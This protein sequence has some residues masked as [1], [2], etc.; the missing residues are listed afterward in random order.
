MR[1]NQ[2]FP[3]LA[4]VLFPVLAATGGPSALAQAPPAAPVRYTEARE[5]EVRREVRLSG[6]VESRTV[7]LVASEVEGLV[8]EMLVREGERVKQ[9]QVLARLRT[10]PLDLRRRAAA[11]ELK[12][13]EARSKLA[14]RGLERAR[15]LFS[16]GAISQQQLDEAFYE[17][18]AWQ[19]RVEK[20]G[21]DI[22]RIE[23]D[24]ERSAIR[25]PF[26]GAVVARRA[27][28]GQWIE[29][30][31][32]VVEMLAHDDLEVV[33]EAPERYYGSLKPGAAVAVT[34]E[35]LPGLE[36]GGRV[37]GVVP[38]ADPQS[39]TFQIRVRISS[40]GGR[41]SAGM[42]AQVA[43]P[44][45][46]PYRAT[47]VPKDAVVADGKERFVYTLDGSST[48][49]VVPVKTGEGVGSWVVVEG[50]VKPGHKVVTRGN[51]RLRPSQS[52]RGEP[53]EYPLP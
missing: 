3:R 44:V 29:L 41:I 45:G 50:G 23:L 33:V 32:P 30:G 11:A 1:H 9:G 16:S 28:I 35:A 6:S 17:V 20:L 39:R 27:D 49:S 12:E 46:E 37:G 42:L 34:L 18:N 5:H 31:G 4:G 15:D 24:L 43:L 25:A 47:L 48:V 38:R 2:A 14:E 8:T 36:E 26:T 19:G 40:A 7:S 53:L 51:E 22:A 52:V 21:A 13:A 10:A